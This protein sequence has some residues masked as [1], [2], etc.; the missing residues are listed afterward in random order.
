MAHLGTSTTELRWSRGCVA[1]LSSLGLLSCTK[2]PSVGFVTGGLQ[3]QRNGSVAPIGD[4]AEELLQPGAHSIGRR[5]DIR[6]GTVSCLAFQ[7][8][9]PVQAIGH[10]H[11]NLRSTL[12]CTPVARWAPLLRARKEP[13]QVLLAGPAFLTV[14]SLSLHFSQV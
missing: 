14:Y 9:S 12:V 1:R 13:L 11:S 5:E 7:P 2:S 10:P 4:G 6:H 8:S 3:A